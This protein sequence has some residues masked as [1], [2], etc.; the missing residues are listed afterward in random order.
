M[1]TLRKS[2]NY[3]KK[4]TIPKIE[5]MY[6]SLNKMYFLILDQYSFETFKIRQDSSCNNRICK[7]DISQKC[8]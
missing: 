8:Y 5:D 7:I 2:C 6:Y 3:Q 4:I 1:V